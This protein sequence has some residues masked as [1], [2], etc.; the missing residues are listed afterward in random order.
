M[1][2]TRVRVRVRNEGQG[3]SGEREQIWR[4][5]ES[6]NLK[7]LPI[8]LLTCVAR[9]EF[10]ALGEIRAKLTLTFRDPLGE[11]ARGCERLW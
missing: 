10:E 5:R 9:E 2:L 4:W 1:A 6:T 7:R 11:A 3:R 8:Q